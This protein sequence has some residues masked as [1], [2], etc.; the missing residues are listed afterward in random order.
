MDKSHN[1]RHSSKNAIPT[2]PQ[3]KP[4]IAQNFHI[5]KK[6]GKEGER[7]RKRGGGDMSKG[8]GEEREERG[9][10]GGGGGVGMPSSRQTTA[11]SW[12]L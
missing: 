10:S 1:M 8:E 11:L 5:K 6:G 12:D 2:K 7:R 3:E 9:S 4:A